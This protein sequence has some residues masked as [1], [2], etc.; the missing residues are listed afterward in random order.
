MATPASQTLDKSLSLL[1]AVIADGGKS[2]LAALAQSCGLP[3]STAHRIVT[4]LRRRGYIASPGRG[5]Y[6]PG[7]ALIRLGAAHG[8][9]EILQRVARPVLRDLTRRTGLTAH[10]GIFEGEM[11]TYLV[12]IDGK[13]DVLTREGMQ[14]EAY[15]SGIGKVLLAALP[16][17]V[18]ELYLNSGP[19]VALT[20]ATIVDPRGLHRALMGVRRDGFALDDR[21]AHA[22]LCCIAAPVRGDDGAVCAAISL[23]GPTTAP[24]RRGVLPDLMAAAAE[25]EGRLQSSPP[26][27]DR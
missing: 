24:D 2:S 23:S 26:T 7:P 14:L 17:A 18:L 22:D 20:A 3:P 13:A 8:L 12:K 9:A 1:A 11:V 21:E 10:L 25:I 4:T 15:C 27:Q 5:C 6:L 16:D 19:F